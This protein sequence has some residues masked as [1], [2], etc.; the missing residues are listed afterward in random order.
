MHVSDCLAL[1]MK[2]PVKR[3]SNKAMSYF[4]V[5]NTARTPS[6]RFG[7]K[8][9]S[10]SNTLNKISYENDFS[11]DA[12]DSKSS[13]F[14]GFE[15]ESDSILISGLKNHTQERK[16]ESMASIRNLRVYRPLIQEDEVEAVNNGGKLSFNEWNNIHLV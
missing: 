16:L 11:L 1:H 12:F 2:N 10:Q 13:S 5:E 8:K 3:F 15:N 6:I 7:N 9:N 4:E 14:K